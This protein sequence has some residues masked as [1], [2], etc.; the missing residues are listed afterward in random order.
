MKYLRALFPLLLFALTG[1]VVLNPDDSTSLAAAA[2]RYS[3]VTNEMNRA[4]VIAAIGEPSAAEGLALT[5][6][7]EISPHNYESLRV[8]FTDGNAVAKIT[9]VSKR[10][11]SNPWWH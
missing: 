8:E 9:R 2:A 6:R 4:E 10:F 5:W 3:K 7:V 1:C 11:S